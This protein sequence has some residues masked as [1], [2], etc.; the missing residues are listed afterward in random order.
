VLN[1]TVEAFGGPKASSVLFEVGIEASEA[2]PLLLFIGIGAMIDFGPLLS[3]PK[4]FSSAPPHSLVSSSPSQLQCCSA[5][6]CVTPPPS[7]SSALR[8][9]HLN[10]SFTGT[11]IQ[12]HRP[13]RRGCYS[14]MALVPIIQPFAIKLVTTKKDRSIGCPTT[15]RMSAA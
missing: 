7:A 3:N 5:L 2:L 8:T 13:D 14:Y 15:P 11:Q 10:L 12:L 9:A 4:M 6:T 1:Q